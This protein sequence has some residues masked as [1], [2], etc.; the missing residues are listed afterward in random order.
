MLQQAKDLLEEGEE[1]KALLETLTAEEWEA[2]TP[3]KDWDVNKVVQHLHGADC[4][5]VLSL[6]EPE[7]FQAALKDPKVTASIMGPTLRGAE[8][9]ERWWSYFTQM[10]E[11][12]GASDP[13]RRC[14][15]FGPDM[16]VKMFTT[17]RQMAGDD[18]RGLPDEENLPGPR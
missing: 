16:G 1:L 4:M 2:P 11:Q 17:A 7:Q 9:F 12:L 13:Q 14:P 6:T 5:A 10:V 8:L 3:F 15:W 18:R